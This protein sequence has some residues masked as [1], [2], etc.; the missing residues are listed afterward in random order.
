[1]TTYQ[2]IVEMGDMRSEQGPGT[3]GLRLVALSF[4]M[5]EMQLV[6]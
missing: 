6:S 2:Y 5:T 1:M 4:F 3:Q